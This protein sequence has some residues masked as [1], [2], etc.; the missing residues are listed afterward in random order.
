MDRGLLVRYFIDEATSGIVGELNDS[1]PTP[2]PLRITPSPGLQ[3]VTES[4]ANR[5]LQWDSIEL[6]GRA[7]AAVSGT[8]LTRLEGSTTGTIEVVLDIHAVAPLNSRISHI[9]FDQESGRFSLGANTTS[10][11]QFRWQS[12]VLGGEWEVPLSSLGRAVVHLVLDTEPPDPEARV[13]LYVN[14]A[15]QARVGGVLPSQAQA[16]QLGT[17]PHYVLGNREV[18]VRS[19]EGRLHYA[20]M[21]TEALSSED[22]LH[23]TALLLVSDDTPSAA[24]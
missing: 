19:F 11:L 13:K 20:A 8:K 21:Y 15:P 7:S 10:R 14:G 2:L 4:G 24:P 3:F 1:A 16:I 5:G 17:D 6:D 12:N 9:G 18:G 22:V 23:N